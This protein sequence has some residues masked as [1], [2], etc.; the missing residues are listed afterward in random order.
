MWVWHTHRCDTHSVVI[1]VSKSQVTLLASCHYDIS[2]R[3]R[4]VSLQ[5]SG[6]T[7]LHLLGQNDWVTE[8]LNYIAV[9]RTA[10]PTL[11]LLNLN[12]DFEIYI[13]ENITTKI[14]ILTGVRPL[15]KIYIYI[16]A[17]RE[18]RSWDCINNSTEA[19]MYS[20]LATMLF[21]KQSMLHS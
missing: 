12:I 16:I 7:S 21:L 9:R 18:S 19:W 13:F 20:P 3:L 5:Y 4:K 17:I 2:R 6:S 8:W 14:Y 11:G 10:P 1:I 15:N